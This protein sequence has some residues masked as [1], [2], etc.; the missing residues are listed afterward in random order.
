VSKID[1]P[2]IELMRR[3][4]RQL[5]I[6][7]LKAHEYLGVLVS[8]PP[9][10]SKTTTIET[11]AAELRIP[12]LVLQN[13]TKYGILRTI[14]ENPEANIFIDDFDDWLTDREIVSIFKAALDKSEKRRIIRAVNRD[15]IRLGLTRVPFNGRIIMSTNADFN[16]LPPAMRTHVDALADRFV[17]V[18]IPWD[19]AE[20]LAY[21]DWWI[22]EGDYFRTPLFFKR[23]RI[24]PLSLREVQ[25]VLNFI[26]ANASALPLTLR[27]VNDVARERKLH[28]D[29][30]AEN[31][32]GYGRTDN[33]FVAA[34]APTVLG[35][36]QRHPHQS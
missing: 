29:G 36:R 33:G 12:L 32:R 17:P 31:L 9:G 34:P 1:P 21:I 22:C 3:R 18:Y 14:A 16:R 5:V 27:M 10:C 20:L 6:R 15:T 7:C 28:P 35:W 26:H 30:W 2:L 19:H 24:P 25:D 4:L 13:A 8:G 23:E 11:T